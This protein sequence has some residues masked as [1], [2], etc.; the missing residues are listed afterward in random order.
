MY[1]YEFQENSPEEERGERGDSVD[2]KVEEPV[3][4]ELVRLVSII[5][6]TFLSV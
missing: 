6:M 3:E 1:Y 4:N 5:L 2:R